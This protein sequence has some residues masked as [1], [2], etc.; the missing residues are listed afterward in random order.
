MHCAAFMLAGS[1]MPV[2]SNPTE[3]SAGCMGIAHNAKCRMSQ[4]P[5][6]PNTFRVRVSVRGGVSRV[7]V[8]CGF[9]VKLVWHSGHSTHSLTFGILD[10]CL[11]CF[12]G[13]EP[14]LNVGS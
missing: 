7:R 10:P 14:V 13:I 8:C 3:A 9:R 6:M 12:L 4:M 11:S 5:G 2:R 1:L